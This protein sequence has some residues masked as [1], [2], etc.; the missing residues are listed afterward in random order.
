MKIKGATD[1]KEKKVEGEIKC[2]R[3]LITCMMGVNNMWRE[4]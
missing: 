2:M 3:V 1:K 4:E